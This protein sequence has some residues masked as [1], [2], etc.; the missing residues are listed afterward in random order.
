MGNIEKMI[1]DAIAKRMRESKEDM[2]FEG[3]SE[4]EG[5]PLDDLL[6][7]TDPKGYEWD[8]ETLEEALISMEDIDEAYGDQLKTYQ[9]GDII[10]TNRYY[11]YRSRS[12]IEN[13][14]HRVL[15]ITSRRDDETGITHYNG[16]LL[17]SKTEKSNKN[18]P[19]FPHN[20]HIDNYSSILYT[21]APYNKEAFIRVDD[22][23]KFTSEDL[24]TSGS[25]KGKA[26]REFINFV[27]MCRDNYKRGVDN[28]KMYWS[29]NF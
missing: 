28:S 19:R 23:V 15:L 12:Y 13:S 1:R 3:V 2:I 6:E 9:V 18:N 5:K 24:S 26:S 7:S 27:Q 21:G 20:I 17:S 16:F 4:D 14:P 25:M 11:S 22:I 29:K 10:M 8:D